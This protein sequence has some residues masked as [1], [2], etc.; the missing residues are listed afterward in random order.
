MLHKNMV[1]PIP[2]KVKFFKQNNIYYVWFV[3]EQTYKKDKK[4]VIDKRIVIGKKIN[5]KTMIPNDN[6]FKIYGEKEVNIIEEAGQFSDTIS[7]GHTIV[8][9]KILKDTGIG[10]LLDEVFQQKSQLIKSLLYFNISSE[11]NKYQNYHDWARRNWIYNE[12]IKSQA[13]ISDLFNN[14]ID[15][16][17]IIDFN[18]KYG[19]L[20][21]K[22]LG[23]KQRT[24]IS[25]DSTNMNTNSK[26]IELA[27]FGHAKDKE[28]LPQ[29]NVAYALDQETGIPLF[30]DLYPGSI[31]DVVQCKQMVEKAKI[32]DFKNLTFIMDRGYFSMK[33][34][35]FILK[36]DYKFIMMA[37]SYN[38]TIKKIESD[39]APTIKNNAS[40][41]IQKFNMFGDKIKA[42][43]FTEYDEEFNVYVFYNHNKAIDDINNYNDNLSQFLSNL[44]I[45]SKFNDDLYRTYKNYLTFEKNENNIITKIGIN[46]ETQQRIL[47]RSG[48][49]TIVS[50]CDMTLE[51][52]IDNYKKRD[53]I[54][55]VFRT[56]KHNLEYK[57]FYAKNDV[58][59]KAKV[60]IAFLASIIRSIFTNKAKQFINSNS[61][62]TTLSTIKL[63]S[64]IEV[65][66]T[67]NVYRTNYALTA[68]QKQILE[69]FKI[70]EKY[71]AEETKKLNQILA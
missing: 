14:W 10:M 70:D 24:F 27:E 48:F 1:V 43:I 68:K 61:S 53:S 28:Y 44:K 8:F 49:F 60:F 11:N 36:N 50:N 21:K 42:K 2:K 4:Y 26:T 19:K 59:L 64:R 3:E 16:S 35:N 66:K 6:Y 20:I 57:K 45:G 69:Y 58:T 38:K 5:D 32:H 7:T 65:T 13:T 31:T 67:N 9:D 62:A 29:V 12:S 33:N 52:I 39:L 56:L 37:K 22:Q 51:E 46:I 34:I 63:L 25:I 54:E 41:Y 15:N 30:Y 23:D 55:K 40:K 71:I 17:M 18:I 47:D